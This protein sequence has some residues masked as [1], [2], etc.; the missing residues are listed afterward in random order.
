MKGHTLMPE[1]VHKTSTKLQLDRHLE[2]INNTIKVTPWCG[3]RP[4][5]QPLPENVHKAVGQVKFG[6]HLIVQTQSKVK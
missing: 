3:G 2:K 1:N 4:I 6:R 5:E